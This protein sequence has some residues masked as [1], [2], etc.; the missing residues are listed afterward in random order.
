MGQGIS[1][2]GTWIQLIAIN[3]LVY[4]LSNSTFLLGLVGFA[5]QIPTLIFSMAGGI[6]A[7]RWSRRNILIIVQILSMLQAAVLAVLF[8]TGAIS[9]ANIIPLGF[10]LGCIN[11]VDIPVR[12]SFVA[13]IVDK[14]EHLPNAIALNSMMF[15]GAR[16]V[17][18]AAAG[19]LVAV[20][21]EGVCFLINAISY[22]AVIAML[23][24]MKIKHTEKEHH[25][26]LGILHGLKEGFNYASNTPAIKHI[27]ILVGML[28]L[29]GMA[30][31]VLMP[32]YAREIFG[33]DARTLGFLVSSVGCGA[34]IGA[35]F[36]AH[37]KNSDGILKIIS[38]ASFVFGACLIAFSFSRIFYISL[39]ILFITGFAMM[40][41]MVACNITVQTI[42]DDSKRG[43]IMSFYAMSFMGM[44]PIGSLF[45]GFL[46]GKIGT[47]QT[48]MFSGIICIVSAVIFFRKTLELHI[49]PEER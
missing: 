34:L 13:D 10:L 15:N 3:W 27:L 35:A 42:V 40:S 25:H 12:H 31:T 49:V 48:V 43:R 5:T 11:S 7:D 8:F 22:L 46:A 32:V 14:K 23:F 26:R 9:V 39:L 37:K 20:F 33:G 47:P 38:A 17:G 41:Q 19:L 44:M 36:L 28:S 24:S 45:W 16:L 21:S 2:I 18:P 29:S 1:L 30:Y 4:R 6:A